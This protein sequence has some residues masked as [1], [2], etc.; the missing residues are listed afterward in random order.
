MAQ[1]I[2]YEQNFSIQKKHKGVRLDKQQMVYLFDDET[3]YKYT[4]KGETVKE[5]KHTENSAITDIAINPAGQMLVLFS[6][7]DLMLVL[8]KN[9]IEIGRLQLDRMGIEDAAGCYFAPD[10]LVAI[11]DQF[12][13]KISKINYNGGLIQKEILLYQA[14]EIKK[15]CDAIDEQGAFIY[16]LDTSVGISVFDIYGKQKSTIGS[17]GIKS[18]QIINQMMVY[19][20]KGE[21]VIQNT[22]TQSKTTIKE[23]VVPNG[24]DRA[25]LVGQNALLSNREEVF[26]FVRK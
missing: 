20:E 21:V 16:L 17:P 7:N 13:S 12:D 3:I 4:I 8:D 24:C 10:G 6:E 19:L 22:A 2:R 23:I 11:Y 15:G 5:F 25:Y 26:F 18:M 9:F 1:V 14:G